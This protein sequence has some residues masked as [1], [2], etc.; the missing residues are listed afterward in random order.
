MVG[1]LNEKKKFVME[2]KDKK[3][4]KAFWNFTLK[5]A[6]WAWR[7]IQLDT[8]EIKCKTFKRKTYHESSYCYILYQSSIFSLFKEV[9][10]HIKCHI[11]ASKLKQNQIQSGLKTSKNISD[12]DIYCDHKDLKIKTYFE[13]NDITTI[14]YDKQEGKCKQSERRWLAETSNY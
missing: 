8:M 4:L 2:I 3:F 14:L 13:V 1:K 10:K 11:V 7:L 12:I 9:L 5:R 6:P